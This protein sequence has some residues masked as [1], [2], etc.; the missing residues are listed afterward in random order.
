MA[1]N[2]WLMQML[3]KTVPDP[4]LFTVDVDAGADP[5]CLGN[6]RGSKF[7]HS[8]VRSQCDCRLCVVESFIPESPKLLSHRTKFGKPHILEMFLTF[9]NIYTSNLPHC[10]ACL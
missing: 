5:Q 10:A 6:C 1:D 8:Y 2:D 7:I 3:P 9:P 4:R